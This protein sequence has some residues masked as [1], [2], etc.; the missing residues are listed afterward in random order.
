[1]SAV[2]EVALA[3][4]LS[5]VREKI[6]AALTSNGRAV[7]DATLI[8]V[9]KFHSADVVRALVACGV[10]DVGENK[11]QE[12]TAK[13]DECAGLGVNWHFIGQ[14]Q[15]NKAAAVRRYA[16]AVHSV[17]R[18]SLVTA[19]DRAGDNAP[20]T[21]TLECFLQIN[22]TDDPAR[23][24]ASWADIPAMSEMLLQARTLTF[25]GVMAVAP[26]DVDPREAFEQVARASELVRTIA[27]QAQAI[28]A[29][30]SHDFEAAIEAGAT[31]LRIGSQIT[32]KRPAPG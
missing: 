8:V 17:D 18:A 2:D 25:A 9:T 16:H 12:A 1:V 19:L 30:M 7:D 24:G 13:Y 3:A 14:L 5:S 11:H 6:A 4:R 22:L 31:H 29:G 20:E 15:S 27:P 28:S 23:G 10:Q 21:K 26:L 32:G